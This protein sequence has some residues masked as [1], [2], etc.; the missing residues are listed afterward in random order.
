MKPIKWNLHLS[1]PP[2]VVFD[3]LTTPGGIEKF[4]AEKATIRQGVIHFAFP[5]GQACEG[6]ILKQVPHREFQLLYF[7]SL[8][9]FRLHPT[10]DGGTDLFLEN[11]QVPKEE[12]QEV[13]A[14]WVS[15]LLNL[16]AAVDFRCDL[17]NHDAK[18][19]WDQ[20]FVGN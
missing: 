3:F 9:E 17:R 20:G 8:V 15:V 19:T 6:K 11:S 16:K 2:Q 18:R 7:D 1:S 13:H 12:H 14:G 4:W 5:N 10:E